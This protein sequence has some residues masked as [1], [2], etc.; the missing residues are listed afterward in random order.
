MS[1]LRLFFIL[2][3]FTAPLLAAEKP[4]A[5][6]PSF[7]TF[8]QAY[9][10][11]NKALAD[12][13]IDEAVSDY[14]AAEK[15]ASTSKGRR[16]AANAAGWAL[17]KGKKW[18]EAKV[19]L[20]RAV[21]E[22]KN[23]KIVL[24]NL[25]CACF[26]LYAYGFEGVE[27]LKEAVKNLEASGENE[28]LLERAKADLDREE[29]YVRTTPEP[30]PSLKGKSFKALL[31]LGDKAQSRGQFTLA[32]KIFK[33]AAA[34]AA[35]SSSK[36]LSANRQGRV[37]LDARKPYEAVAYFEEAVRYKP[38]EKVYLNNLAYSYWAFYDS[39]KGKV[40]ALKKAVDTYYKLNSMDSSFHTDML[41]MALDELKEAD[42]EATKSYTVHEDSADKDSK[43]NNDNGGAS[44]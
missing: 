37:L 12:N 41:K 9:T 27:E 14:E 30:E 36:A 23:S 29:I 17:I 8:K 1:L 13:K 11:G 19:A 35:S 21:Q 40:P 32:L 15:L 31:A 24:K 26:N 5:K 44:Q 4:A 43:G 22:D 18:R 28:E 25:G 16:D 33:Q 38:A 42:P 39:G 20:T 7:P 3:L 34:T 2:C 10:A 6:G